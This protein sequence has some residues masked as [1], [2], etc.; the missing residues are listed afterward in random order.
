MVRSRQCALN[1]S[2]CQCCRS[3][4]MDGSVGAQICLALRLGSGAVRQ[5]VYTGRNRDR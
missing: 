1:V 3:S 4:L 2:Y 5:A